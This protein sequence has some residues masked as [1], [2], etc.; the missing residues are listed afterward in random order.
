MPAI[1]A[2]LGEHDRKQKQAP[3]LRALANDIS[4]TIVEVTV[5]PKDAIDAD[6]FQNLQRYVGKPLTGDIVIDELLNVMNALPHKMKGVT[7]IGYRD[8]NLTGAILRLDFH[9]GFPKNTTRGWS[10]RTRI[11]SPDQASTNSNGDMDFE[12]GLDR[13]NYAWDT[14]MIDHALKAVPDKEVVIECSRYL[15]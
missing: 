9:T 14:Q 11:E 13:A 10:H 8:E 7:V 3:K 4:N 5:T 15:Q 2:K 12:Y 1:H 6:A